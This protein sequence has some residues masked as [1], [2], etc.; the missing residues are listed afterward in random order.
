MGKIIGIDLGI[1]NSAGASWKPAGLRSSQTRIR[2]LGIPRMVLS[3][4]TFARF[5]SADIEG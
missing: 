1:T 2:R 3:D 5:R 4:W